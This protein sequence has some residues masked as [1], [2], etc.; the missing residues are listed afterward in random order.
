VS[1]A[2]AMAVSAVAGWAATRR[3]PELVQE[4]KG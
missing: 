3:V 4:V 1:V 2:V